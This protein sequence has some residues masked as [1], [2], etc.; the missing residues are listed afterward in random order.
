MKKMIM[1]SALLISQ[2]VF[3]GTFM[4]AAWANEV[5][6]AWNSNSTLTSKLGKKW[7][8]NDG[9]RGY[10][11][12]QIYRDKCGESSKIQL[13]IVPQDGKAVCARGGKP[14]GKALDSSYDYVMHASDK[15]WT[16]IGK[17][18]FGCGAMGAMATGKLKFEGPKMEAMSVMGPFGSFLTLTGSVGGDKSSCAQ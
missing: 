12:I 9:K 3:A 8:K 18:S 10:K 14:D 15:D 16:C 11:L 7:I 2:G 4:D 6:Q 13:T 17:G 1:I 5:C